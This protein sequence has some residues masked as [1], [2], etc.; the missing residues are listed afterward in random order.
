[1][2][3]KEET[4]VSSPNGKKTTTLFE[5][6]FPPR[7]FLRKSSS[8]RQDRWMHKVAAL[9]L[10]DQLLVSTSNMFFFHQVA[11]ESVL[12]PRPTGVSV[13]VLVCVDRCR[14]FSRAD[15]AFCIL[16]RLHEK[17]IC[18]TFFLHG[19]AFICFT[20]HNSLNGIYC[21]NNKKQETQE[22]LFIQSFVRQDWL[23]HFSY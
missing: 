10:A 4:K 22:V 13:C 19:A 14:L 5:N 16:S 11:G 21:R 17:S 15:E 18:P 7:M 1:M 6:H 20:S 23:L 2:K 9:W 3:K 12:F 8:S